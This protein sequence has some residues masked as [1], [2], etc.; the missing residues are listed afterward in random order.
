MRCK[1]CDT[2]LTDEELEFLSKNRKREFEEEMCF[3]CLGVV[4]DTLKDFE[5][6]NDQQ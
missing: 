2:I 1:A 6:E 3:K 4:A 5:E